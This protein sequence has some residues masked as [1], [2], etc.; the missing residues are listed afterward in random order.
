M[1]K[2]E[3]WYVVLGALCYGTTLVLVSCE[4]D[5]DAGKAPAGTK[6]GSMGNPEGTRASTAE[7]VSSGQPTSSTRASTENGRRQP[8]ASE[9][10]P[11]HADEDGPRA[12]RTNHDTATADGGPSHAD[13]DGPLARGDEADASACPSGMVRVP[14]GAFWVGARTGAKDEQPR[15]ETKMHEFCIDRTEVTV[16]QWERCRKSKQ[17]SSAV[18]GQKTCNA[19]RA[20]RANHP[21]NCVSWTQAEQ[22]CQANGK[23]L[24]TEFEWEYA[25]RGGAEMRRFPW[26]NES[27]DGRTCWKRP[28]SCEVGSY[29]PGAFGLVDI[30]GNVWE[31][32]ESHYAPSYPW[33]REYGTAR[34]YRGGSWSRRFEKW[35][36]PT[37]RNR[38]A[39][40][41]WGSHLGFRC[42]ADLKSAHCP[43]GAREGRC[44]HGV[45]RVDCPAPLRWNGAR[46]AE[47][48]APLCRPGMH[49]QPGLGCVFEER[50]KRAAPQ[51]DSD[52]TQGVVMQRSPGFDADCQLH[53]P[54][55]PRAWRLTGGTH[56]GRNLVGQGR[57]CKNRDV[58]VGWNSACCPH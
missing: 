16:A 15:F 2:R 32:T 50:P 29:E 36:S 52:P 18:R 44:L 11:S 5:N 55:R 10:E 28:R 40:H 25:A 48:A 53:Q 46:C 45:E 17:C 6:K 42:A 12:H 13:E 34:V 3:R 1:A 57:G 38:Y 47:P 19:G 37:L 9:R 22:F 43:Y 7:A 54:G 41:K 58:G 49:Q 14:A 51:T 20:E 8:R 31:W 23:R 21:I 35:L 39:E 33:P 30:V 56:H 26:G 4:Q 27:P 24:P